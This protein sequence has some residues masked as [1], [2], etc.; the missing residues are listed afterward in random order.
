MGNDPVFML[1]VQG[2]S[3]L[4]AGIFDGDLIVVRRQPDARNGEIVAALIG[5]EE[6]TVKRLRKESDRVVLLP[7]NP[8]HDPIVLTKD[9]E[10]L[11]RVIAVLRTVR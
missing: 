5:G 8:A 9:V 6:A 1:R 4:N 2:D 3:M 10:I 11:G 7:E